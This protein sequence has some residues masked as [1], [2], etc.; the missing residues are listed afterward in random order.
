[1]IDLQQE[2]YKTV[3]AGIGDVIKDRLNR[4][5]SD[6]PLNKMIDSVVLSKQNEISKLIKESIDGALTV[7]F[8]KEIKEAISHKLAKILI[9]KMEGEIEKVANNLRNSPEFRAK[10]T[11]A[12]TD[13]INSMNK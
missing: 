2:I 8:R 12:I 1:M 13:V 10:V 7:D 9:S 4:G 6:N 3:L 11:L 5:Y